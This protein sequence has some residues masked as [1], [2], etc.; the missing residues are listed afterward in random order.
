MAKKKRKPKSPAEE[1]ADPLEGF[2]SITPQ[3]LAPK[4][5]QDFQT[6]LARLRVQID[7]QKAAHRKQRLA[8]GLSE[9][10][11]TG[12]PLPAVVLR[13]AKPSGRLAKGASRIGAL[14]DL[15]R[16]IEWPVYKGRKL[17]F[18]AQINLKELGGFTDAAD[19]PRDGWLYAFDLVTN[20]RDVDAS[21]VVF[22]HRGADASE[23]KRATA[24][25]EDDIWPDWTN[26]R[27]YDLVPVAFAPAPKDEV[28]GE[29]YRPSPQAG[30]LFGEM[31]GGFGTAGEVA[32]TEFRDG[33]DWI[34]LLAV[35][36]VGSMTWSDAGH[37]YL[38]IRRSAL[39]RGDFSDVI[40]AVGSG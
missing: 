18:V 16:G 12:E 22:V 6:V 8:R 10:A 23:L 17:P 32:D 7:E 33:D 24:P 31:Y 14:P 15:P 30:W 36:S 39:A 3:D 2:E 35:L 19:A 38:L 4:P 20:D 5:Q 11:G 25:A 28:L 26:R 9:A 21:P 1:L 13:K 27:V 34:N 40:S 37:L 29:S